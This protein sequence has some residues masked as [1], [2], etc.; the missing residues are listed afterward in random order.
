MEYKEI[1]MKLKATVAGLIVAASTMAA[2]L[3]SQAAW[4]NTH[5]KHHYASGWHMVSK[6]SGIPHAATWQEYTSGVYLQ[7]MR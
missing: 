5:H 2:V 6:H 7:P 4:A 3:S 1:N